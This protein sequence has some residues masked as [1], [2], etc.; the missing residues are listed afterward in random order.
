MPEVNYT[1]VMDITRPIVWDFVRDMNN[2]APL[3]K[4]YQTH[5]VLND[6]ESIWTVKG[7]VGPISRTTKFH[8]TITEW[9]EGDRVAFTLKGLNESITGE[10]AIMLTDRDD[11]PGTDIRGEATLEFGGSM[12]PVLNQL[13]GPW[14]QQG[15]DELV[16]AI[17]T[18]LQPT[19]VRP[20]RPF[21]LGRWAQSAWR[22]LRSG[23][24]AVFGSREK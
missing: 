17:V 12:G 16:T 4:G 11:S 7:E 8:I 5:E 18:T 21:F 20:S 3:A 10:G 1:A 15:A 9:H 22:L 2:W 6:R 23:V 19:Y 24:A 14:V 13:I